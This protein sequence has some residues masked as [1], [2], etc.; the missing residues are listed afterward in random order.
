MAND[1]TAEQRRARNATLEAWKRE[2]L[3]QYKLRFNI[4]T[5]KDLIEKLD[6]QENIQGYLKSLIRAD[7][8]RDPS[9]A[10]ADQ[11]EQEEQSGQE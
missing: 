5:D 1:L 11:G 3:R 2:N 9:T 6:A 7:I 10:S 8:A 4:R